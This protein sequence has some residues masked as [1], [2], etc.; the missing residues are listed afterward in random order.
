MYTLIAIT[1]IGVLA[2][3]SDIFN[4]RKVLYPLTLAGLLVALVLTILDWDT[5]IRYFSDMMYFDNYAVAFSGVLIFITFLWFLLSENFLKNNSRITEFTALVSFSLAASVVMV[6]YADLILLF[7][8]IEILS[9]AMYILAASNKQ[10]YKSNEAGFKYFLMGA[11]AS[12]FLLFGITL[13]YG[14]SASFNLREI[15]AYVSVNQN[16]LPDIFYMGILLTLVG[17]AFKVS[18]APFHFWAPDVYDGSPTPFTAYMTTVVKVAAFA[19]FLRLFIV[20]F[21]TIADWW[22]P[23]VAGISALSMLAGNIMAVYQ[24]SL[25][26]MLAYSSIAHAGYML[27]AIV[28]INNDS[29]NALLFYATAYSIGSIAIFVLVLSMTN[30]GNE[31]ISSLKGFS[32][33]NQLPALVITVALLSF[34]GIPPIAGFFGKYYVFVAALKNDYTWLVLIGVLSSLIGLLSSS[35]QLSQGQDNQYAGHEQR[36][37]SS[38][39]KLPI[40][41]GKA[42]IID[43]LHQVHRRSPRAAACE[44]INH[45]K[46]LYGSD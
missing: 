35:S 10:E 45:F 6:S 46:H 18:A 19:A 24:K 1:G 44:G 40:G 42:I 32:R 20:C 30:F 43:K 29:P 3:L 41:T 33:T 11:F 13:M 12:G 9:I 28:A 5:N 34:A 15:A 21:S 14:A 8:G 22:A 39:T 17:L 2:M 26:R 31:M 27:M 23:V 25:K 4:F 36:G 38:N 37:R 7:L 16:D